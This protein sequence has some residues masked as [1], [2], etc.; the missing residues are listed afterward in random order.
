MNT[1]G[2]I[3]YRLGHS[4][5]KKYFTNK[6]SLENISEC[7]Y[8]NF[9]LDAIV[10]FPALISNN[11]SIKGLNCTIPYKQDIMTYLDEIDAEAKQIGA[12]NTIKIIRT[13]DKVRLKG[14][15]TDCYGFEMSLK[16][17]LS[18]YHKKA[19]VLGTG[20]ASKS[21]HF[22]LNELNIEAISV[23]RTANPKLNI[24][25]YEQLN[26]NIISEHKLII[27]AT[28]LGTFP[29]VDEC[30]NIPYKYITK[31]HYLYDL[32]YNPACTL[33]LEKGKEMGS[34]IKN[35]DEM[36]RLQA[37]RAWEIWNNNNLK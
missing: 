32:V 29:K 8:E 23:S 36:L 35:G 26:E 3:G 31:K 34:I 18:N 4:F 13:N 11:L 14:F 37:E 16:P 24:L 30:P 21:V 20:G 2:L 22:V 7:I 15:N 9:E 25:S 27:N 1:Y 5:S 6:F 33:F 12:V 19:L 17:L 10:D 28:P